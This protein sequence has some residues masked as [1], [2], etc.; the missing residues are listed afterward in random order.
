MTR[1]P[2]PESIWQVD[3][4]RC[5]LK[6]DTGQRLWALV[7]CSSEGQFEKVAFCPQDKS[8]SDWI[9]ARLRQWICESARPTS[10]QVFRPQ[11]LPAISQA[12]T[13]LGIAVTPTRRTIALKERLEIQAQLYPQLDGYVQEPYDPLSIDLAPPEPIPEE[14]RPKAWQ[15][16]AVSRSDMLALTERTIPIEDCTLLGSLLGVNPDALVPG[17]VFYGERRALALAQW[18]QQAKPVSVHFIS[19]DPH[20]VILEAGLGDR[21][22]MATFEDVTV[23]HAASKF[24]QRKS[25]GRG[26]HFLMVMPDSS[27]QTTTG[28]WLLENSP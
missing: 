27:G 28:L 24:E 11:S 10:V 15:F 19:G 14:L 25:L 20:G 4:Y 3:F 7:V 12:A 9:A 18:L 23:L 21:W 2:H 16:A 6:D 26:I 5:P 17:I 8:N 13:S 22:V 1:S